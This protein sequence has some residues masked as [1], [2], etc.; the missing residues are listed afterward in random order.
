M[1]VILMGADNISEK[2]FS[3]P[4]QGFNNKQAIS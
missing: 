1:Q 3:I 4:N 2:I